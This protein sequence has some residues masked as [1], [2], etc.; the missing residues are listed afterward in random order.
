[1]DELGQKNIQPR[2]GIKKKNDSI[3]SINKNGKYTEISIL[4]ELFEKS[5]NIELLYLLNLYRIENN[6]IDKNIDNY[7]NQNIVSEHPFPHI[8]FF[9]ENKHH[10]T[11]GRYSVYLHAVILS[12]I[13]KVT[14]VMDKKP[15]F[16]NDFL[17]YYNDNFNLIIDKNFLSND[18]LLFDIIV[19]VPFYSG[20]H[21]F[22][23]ARKIGA[24]LFSFIF[25]SPNWIIKYREGVDSTEYYWANYKK[26]LIDSDK[27]IVPSYESKKYLLEWINISDDKAQVLY[28]TINQVVA[29]KYKDSSTTIE[30]DVLFITRMTE[31]KSIIPIIKNCR[32]NEFHFHI[33]GKILNNNIKNLIDNLIKDGYNITIYENVT[34]SVKF[35][36]V[37]KC[38]MII[39][40]SLFEGFGIPP[41]EAIYMNKPIVVYNLPV[42]K[43]V[44]GNAVIYAEW[45]NPKDFVD[46]MRNYLVPL[47]NDD[48]EKVKEIATIKYNFNKMIPIF[49]IPKITAGMIVYNGEEYIKY[50]IMS[51]YHLLYEIII[52]EGSVDM[53]S[54][55]YH[56]TDKTNEIIEE[57]KSIDYAK[58][59]K[60]IKFNTFW[61]DKIEMQNNI[62]KFITG[63]F[64]LKLDFDEIWKPETLIDAINLFLKDENLTVLKM[65]FYHFWTN[66]NTIAKDEGGKWSTKHPRI[67][68][69]SKDFKHVGSF[70]YFVNIKTAKKVAAPFYKEVEYSGD[71]IYHFGYA[72]K[73]DAVNNK[74]AYYK[75]RKIEKVANN[76]Y[77]NWKMGELTQPTQNSISGAEEFKGKLPLILNEHPYLNIKD[78]REVK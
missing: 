49:N 65:P 73:L 58:K 54:D 70:N 15:P 78:I 56:S 29:S 6:H 53:Y 60:Y 28:P 3:F 51:I 2:M 40:P 41:L 59:I 23:Y 7:T 34:D 61:K 9:I 43:E 42:F 44:Y 19:G 8:A 67:W 63:D 24:K 66:F 64:Y 22:N 47:S 77:Q 71:R 45:N 68:R 52:V 10:Y 76:T 21:A 31:Y 46:K 30:Y 33:L 20:L 39:H 75:N 36:M 12:L 26:V 27:I 32:K 11:G 72:R 18:S 57:L 62:A 5:T 50:S 38:K 37:S 16:Y 48:T 69:W 25:E 35:N 55:T 14:V 13:T 74:I 1:M 4:S 17:L